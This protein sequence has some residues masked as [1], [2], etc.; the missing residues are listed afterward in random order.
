MKK[1]AFFLPQFHSIKENDEWWGEG[2]TEW[3]NVKKA[4]KLYENHVQP[5]TPLDNNYYCLLDKNTV[6]WQTSLMK[7]YCIDGLIYYHYYFCGDLLLEK[8][9]E[10]LLKW[11]DI[12]QPFF[13]CWANHSWYRSWN[14]TKELL[15]EHICVDNEKDLE[16][17]I[18]SKYMQSRIGNSFSQVKKFLQMDKKVLFVGSTCQIAGLK[19]FLKRDYENLICVDFIC[20]GTP[21]PKVWKDY[22]D[23][24][25]ENELITAVNFKD[26]KYGWNN[27][28]LKISTDKKTFCCVGKQTYY[29]TGYYNFLYSR[30]SC[31]NCIFKGNTRASDI[32]LSDCWGYANIA[33]EMTDNNGLSCIVCH[34]PKGKNLYN[35][36]IKDVNWKKMS[37]DDLIKY[38]SN[39]NKSA[40]MGERRES[41]WDEY[42]VLDKKELFAKYCSPQEIPTNNNIVKKIVEGFKRIIGVKL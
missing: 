6:E 35:E 9:A 14:G 11:K 39:Y 31:S 22:L 4:K 21:S 23:T 34:S 19:S 32:T 15:A 5:I 30:P 25:F 16:K 24:F 36:I 26:K 8:P 27:F 10:N 41:F 3:V 33:P 29:F 1:Y 13:F 28:A 17:L 42:N 2:F 7:K 20:L 40:P 12:D 38:N 37:F 18:G